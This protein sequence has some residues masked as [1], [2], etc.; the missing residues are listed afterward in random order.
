MK[1]IL[2]ISAVLLFSSVALAQSDGY[3]SYPYATYKFEQMAPDC[4]VPQP[5]STLTT[6]QAVADAIPAIPWTVVANKV[7]TPAVIYPGFPHLSRV[8]GKMSPEYIP[9]VV[10]PIKNKMLPY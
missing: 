5:W 9:N 8:P 1:T 2:L 3:P 6:Q 4:N 10:F 7:P